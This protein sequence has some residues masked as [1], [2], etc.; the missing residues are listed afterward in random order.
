M[1][2][3]F[4]LED[5]VP[6]AEAISAIVEKRL[7]LDI[8]WATSLKDARDMLQGFKVEYV[9]AVVDL[10][11]PDATVFEALE[12]TRGHGIPTIVFTSNMDEDLRKTIWN[13]GIVDYVLKDRERSMDYLVSMLRRLHRNPGVKTLIVDDSM[14]MR[15]HYAELLQNHRYQVLQARNGEE[16]LQT[17]ERHPEIRLALVDYVMPGMD[18]LELTV[19][20]RHTHS[21]EDLS[22]IA[23]SGQDNEEISA[24]FIKS[25]ANDYIDKRMSL[26]GFYCR[27]SHQVDMLENIQLLREAGHRDFLTGLHNRRY[28]FDTGRVLL[29]A[30]QRGGRNVVLAM[31]DIDHFKKVNDTYGHDVGDQVIRD[32][33]RTLRRRFRES[34][35]V[36]RFGGEEFCVLLSDT[37]ANEAPRIFEELRQEVEQT[38][39]ESIYGEVACTISIGVCC[40]RDENLETMISRADALLYAAKNAGRNRVES[41]E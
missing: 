32:L 1:P 6:T 9:A 16:A 26:E 28:F 31:L 14:V 39:T 38:P 37:P 30:A 36:A 8:V 21:K 35:L 27:I 24:Q 23:L 4:L 15:A 10:A 12:L 18:G 5:S 11:L 29:A 40:T 25:G 17:L 3:V 2:S 33:A 20:I 41:A 7:E 19:A 13:Y 22:I 34:D